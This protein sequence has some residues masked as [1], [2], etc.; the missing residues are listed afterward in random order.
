[1]YLAISLDLEDEKEQGC[2]WDAVNHITKNF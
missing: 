2:N 1:M